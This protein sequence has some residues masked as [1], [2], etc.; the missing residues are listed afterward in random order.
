[1]QTTGVW[2]FRIDRATTGL[3]IEKLTIPTGSPRQQENAVLEIEVFNQSQFPQPFGNFFGVVVLSFEGIHQ[4]QAH[5]IGHFDL[6]GHG[7]AVGSTTVAHPCFVTG[8][9]VATVNI[10]NGNR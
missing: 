9:S 10:Y 6:N 1:V 7:A 4:T 3:G 2:S 5:Q 8:P